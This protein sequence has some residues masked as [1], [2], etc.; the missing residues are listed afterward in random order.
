[1]DI[2]PEDH[3]RQK[4]TELKCIGLQWADRANKVHGVLL[5]KS[6]TLFHIVLISH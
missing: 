6:L 1:M 5:I 3:F 2:K 4:L